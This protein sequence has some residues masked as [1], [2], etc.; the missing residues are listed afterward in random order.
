[1]RDVRSAAASKRAAT[2]SPG[3]T[4]AAGESVAW[5][6]PG[7]ATPAYTRVTVRLDITQ[8]WDG[9]PARTNEAVGLVLSRDTAGSWLLEIDAPFHGDPAPAA[10]TGSTPALWN[11][12]VVEIFLLAPPDH[13]LEVEIGPHGHHLVLE[14][15]GV[16]RPTREGLPLDLQVERAG[17]R[18]RARARIDSGLVPAGVTRVNAYAVHG[19][20]SRRRHLA[21]SA[22]PGETPDFHRLGQFAALAPELRDTEDPSLP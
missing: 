2:Y 1:M 10:R 14:L 6:T 20:G 7:R 17:D 11:H 4:A 9:L 22:V 8:T 18:W 21:F 12:E 13:Y 5:A 15:R 3:S 19:E 16:R